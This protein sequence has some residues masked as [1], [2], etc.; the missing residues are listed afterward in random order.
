MGKE[1]N[2]G[3]NFEKEAL[4]VLSRSELASKWIYS[5]NKTRQKTKCA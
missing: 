5:A 4:H 3:R 2:V 1:I